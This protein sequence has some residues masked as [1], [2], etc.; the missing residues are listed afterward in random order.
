MTLG[1]HILALLSHLQRGERGFT[2]MIADVVQRAHTLIAPR[3]QE[4][5]NLPDLAMELG[6]RYPSRR[7]SFAS[8]MGISLQ[9][10][11]LSARIQKAQDFLLNTSKSVKEI[12]E[13]LGFDSLSHFSAQFKRRTGK[14]PN[15]R[16]G[17]F[18]KWNMQKR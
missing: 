4:P 9:E 2:K 5:L 3:C 12:A 18:A 11:Y 7:H 14:S 16:R 17:K 15:P 1:L 6:V 8:R 13:L 10:H